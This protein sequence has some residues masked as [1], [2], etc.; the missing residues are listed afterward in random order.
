MSCWADA[1]L[2]ACA[3]TMAAF[4]AAVQL[5]A[6]PAAAPPH[7]MAP[8]A[9][10]SVAG[11]ENRLPE[12]LAAKA[13]ATASS[14]HNQHYLAKFAID[15]RIPPAGSR[16]ADLNAAWCVLKARSGDQAQFTLQ[17]SQPVEAAEVVYYGRTSWFMN[18]CWKDYELYLDDRAEPVVKGTLKMIHGPQRIK[19]PPGKVQKIT[20]KFLNSYGGYNPGAAEIM[21]FAVSP[22]DEQLAAITAAATMRVAVHGGFQVPPELIPPIDRPDREHLLALIRQL[23]DKAGACQPSTMS[24]IEA[25]KD[26]PHAGAAGAAAGG[27]Q[28]TRNPVAERLAALAAELSSATPEQLVHLQRRAL[29]YDVDRLLVVNATRSKPRTFTPITTKGSATAGGCTSST[30]TNRTPSR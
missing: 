5:Q 4:L 13:T 24:A 12:N 8:P 6:A 2:G 18:E 15:G 21:V 9:P 11:G 25:E 29:L 7:G 19:L 14:E 27:S 30:R 17:W 28:P 23:I 22:T 16:T 20:L 1:V 26:T 10:P 3:T